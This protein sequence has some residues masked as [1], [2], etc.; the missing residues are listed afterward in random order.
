MSLTPR[1]ALLNSLNDSLNEQELKQLCFELHIDLDNLIGSTKRQKL[2]SLIR[3][4]QQYR[5]LQLLR[6]WLEEERPTKDWKT[7]IANLRNPLGVENQSPSNAGSIKKLYDSSMPSLTNHLEKLLFESIFYKYS[8]IIGNLILF[9]LL[10]WVCV[11]IAFFVFFWSRTELWIYLYLSTFPI[12]V[13]LY[14]CWDF[15]IA[16]VYRTAKR[17]GYY[18]LTTDE[19]EKIKGKLLKDQ[20]MGIGNILIPIFIEKYLFTNET[21]V[22]KKWK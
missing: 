9:Q 18:K 11:G 8:T 14:T 15:V 2:S 13:I 12:P 22:L 17:N 4:C 10:I 1:R 16:N 20:Y 7:K 3:H 21:H 5:K 19:R 6:G